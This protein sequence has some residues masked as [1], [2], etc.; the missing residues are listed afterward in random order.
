M[1]ILLFI[2]GRHIQF[3]SQLMVFFGEI[4]LPVGGS[5]FFFFKFRVVSQAI[6]IGGEKV[7]LVI[8]KLLNHIMLYLLSIMIIAGY[9]NAVVITQRIICAQRN[10]IRKRPGLRSPVFGIIAIRLSYRSQN[11]PCLYYSD[12]I[13]LSFRTL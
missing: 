1:I 12:V 4:M 5:I 3:N 8:I 6:V 13:R 10:N 2:R 11:I 9:S 7:I